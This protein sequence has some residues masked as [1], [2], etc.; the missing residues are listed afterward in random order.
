MPT[1]AVKKRLLDKHL[2]ESLSGDE[3]DRLCFLYGLEVDDVVSWG[4][5]K[6]YFFER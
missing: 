6:T 3:I 4:S 2:K 5:I 1:I